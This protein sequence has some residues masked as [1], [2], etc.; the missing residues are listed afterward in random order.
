M[1]R[2]LILYVSLLSITN[3]FADDNNHQK[4][5]VGNFKNLVFE[6]GGIKGISYI[7]AALAFKDA[8]YYDEVSGTYSFKNISG[9]SIGCVFGLAIALDI[10]PNKMYDLALETD[11]R[12]LLDP[13]VNALTSVPKFEKKYSLNLANYF[14]YVKNL[15]N[16]VSQV[17]RLWVIDES[18]GMTDTEKIEGWIFEKLVPLSR[19]HGRINEATT[20]SELADISGH[21]LTCFAS[22][23]ID[24][25]IIRYSPD[26]SPTVSIREAIT[27]SITLPILFKPQSV[28]EPTTNNGPDMGINDIEYQLIVD[29]GLFNNF[30]IYEYDEYTSNGQQVK[31]Y[32]KTLGISLHSTPQHL[33]NHV[34]VGDTVN[35]VNKVNEVG[36]ISNDV[37]HLTNITSNDLCH[38]TNQLSKLRQTLKDCECWTMAQKKY[39][40]KH[41]DYQNYH[42][43]KHFRIPT[44]YYLRA[45]LSSLIGARS[46]LQYSGD[47][48]N[49][50]RII[51]LQSPLQLLEFN[52]T[53]HK[54]HRAII[55]AKV[56][57]LKGF[58]II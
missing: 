44:P 5:A 47:P 19:Y 36:L 4:P 24:P 20:L 25:K 54:V 42:F 12:D 55:C 29:G 37:C 53:R 50:K 58:G 56:K 15:F 57:T 41:N 23:I 18:P 26:L 43:T 34:G 46:Y 30:P 7:G 14:V 13:K 2:F 1:S 10:N 27:T 8:G 16:Y 38:S 28:R 11:F 9:T 17:A 3:L 45:L 40:K 48:L 32:A 39:N 33:K 52:L 49:A 31:N 6:G 22:R 21:K 51:Y 35:E